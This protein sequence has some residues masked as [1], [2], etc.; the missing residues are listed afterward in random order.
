[1]RP[2]A[3]EPR[4]RPATLPDAGP[5]RFLRLDDTL[6][7]AV[8]DAPRPAYDAATIETGLRDLDWVAERAMA[9]ERVM[10]WLG[11]RGSIVPMKLFTLFASDDSART[12]LARRARSLRSV[13]ERLDGAREWGVRIAVDP[14]RARA[15]AAASAKPAKVTSGTSFLLARKTQ[16]D[17]EQT[18]GTRARE[19]A[20]R[21]FD[22]LSP[23]SRD[24]FCR[25]LTSGAAGSR[26]ALDAVLLV[27]GTRTPELEREV[28]R[29]ARS[30]APL[31]LDLTLTGPWPPY[32]FV[33]R[34]ARA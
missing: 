33:D 13:L 19:E 6:T 4:K 8:C 22:A 27:D 24:A 17:A 14:A 18:A 5:L 3:D 28:E 20:A 25:D 26:L 16:R 31:G 11:A 9:H 12:A 29:L 30:L 21:V 23:L 7:L 10:E 2:P 15:M 32:H 34:G 1:M